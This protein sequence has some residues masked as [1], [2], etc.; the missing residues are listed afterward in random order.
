MA[1]LERSFGSNTCRCTG[2]RPILDT[3][4]SYAVDASPKLC[5]RIRDI[6]DLNHCCKSKD[7][8]GRKSSIKSIDSD[9]SI[10]NDVTKVR[11]EDKIVISFGDSK[12]FK[13][14]NEDEIFQV[15]N[16]YGVD[17]YMLVDG[18]TAKGRKDYL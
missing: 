15:W 11:T 9:W 3:V 14:F 17:S 1:Q 5:Q 16:K 7:N 13:L 2:F 12:F 8:H 4:K 6:E 10:I 18:N